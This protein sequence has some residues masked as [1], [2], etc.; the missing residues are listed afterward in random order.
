VLVWVGI[1]FPLDTFFFSPLGY[2]HENRV[3]QH[4]RDAEISVMT[5]QPRVALHPV[6]LAGWQPRH[7]IVGTRRRAE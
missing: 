6:G 1:W 7:A 3:L 4:L 5:W 2:G